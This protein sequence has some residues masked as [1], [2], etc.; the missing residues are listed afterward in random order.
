MNTGLKDHGNSSWILVYHSPGVATFWIHSGTLWYL[1]LVILTLGQQRPGSDGGCPSCM[2]SC[3]RGSVELSV[4]PDVYNTS[5][6]TPD[7]AMKSLLFQNSDS[8]PWVTL[9]E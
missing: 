5:V 7:T 4:L 6:A 1:F 3:S 9:S 8:R 2:S